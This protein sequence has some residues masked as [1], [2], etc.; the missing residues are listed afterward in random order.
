MKTLRNRS[1]K[2][3]TDIK[4]K[5]WKRMIVSKRRKEVAAPHCCCL[6]KSDEQAAVKAWPCTM[7]LCTRTFAVAPSAHLDNL[8]QPTIVSL[9]SPPW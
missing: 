8:S 6:G 1:H 9:L 3:V 4:K 5:K 2:G 7:P